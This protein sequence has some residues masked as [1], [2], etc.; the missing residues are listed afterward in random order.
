MC[1]PRPNGAGKPNRPWYPPL[2]RLSASQPSC[3]F[4]TP[5][6][7]CLAVW[8]E[9][10]PGRYRRCIP[11]H[12]SRHR[13]GD[14]RDYRQTADR[15]VHCI[16]RDHGPHQRHHPLAVSLP[17]EGGRPAQDRPEP[18]AQCRREGSGRTSARCVDI[19]PLCRTIGTGQGAPG[20][21]RLCFARVQYAVD[22]GDWASAQNVWDHLRW[23]IRIGKRPSSLKDTPLEVY[24]A[25]AD[26]VLPASCGCPSLIPQ[27]RS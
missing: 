9:H 22:C 1:R 15:P 16:R 14:P 7:H 26:T 27:T 20:L 12:G 6:A 25:K 10:L 4:P 23:T 21:P 24:C 5:A 13:D 8:P 17:L 2:A 11:A 18:G 19:G 3:Q